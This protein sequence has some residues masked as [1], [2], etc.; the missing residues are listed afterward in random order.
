MKTTTFKREIRSVCP[1][2][3]GK[4]TFLA[5]Y[6]MG[7][8]VKEEFEI[9]RCHTCDAIYVANPIHRDCLG[10][11]YNETYFSGGGM[12]DSVDYEANIKVQDKFF[13]KY[14]WQM[15]YQLRQYDLSKGIKWLDVGCALGN[16]LDWARNRYEAQTFGIEFTEYGKKFTKERGHEVLG[17]FIEDAVGKG[18]DLSFD[19]VSA[20]EVLE[21]LYDPMNF[22]EQVPKLLA[23]GGVFHYSTGNPPRDPARITPWGYIRP[24]VHIVFYSPKCMIWIFNKVGLK[25]HQRKQ[26][27]FVKNK[28]YT[29]KLNW[30]QKLIYIACWLGFDLLGTFQPDGV[31]AKN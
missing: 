16:T 8:I 4:S 30:K 25:A 21:H 18:H 19:V 20:Y 14:D 15:V 6:K 17:T 23:S 12:D 1:V 5:G 27:P 13:A 26:F 10:D 22:F 2:C 7:K 11:I 31:R 29:P 3:Q 28:L 9:R 24:E